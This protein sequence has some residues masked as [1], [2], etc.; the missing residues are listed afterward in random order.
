MASLAS[1]IGAADQGIEPVP[2]SRRVLGVWDQFVLWA[3]LG[4]NGLAPWLGASLP[5]FLVSFVLLVV[6]GRLTERET[7]PVAARS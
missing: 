2:Q 1:K 3:D 4:I 7:S 6:V 5:S